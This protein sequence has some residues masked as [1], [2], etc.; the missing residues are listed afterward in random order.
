MIHD[1]PIDIEAYEANS[2]LFRREAW[3]AVARILVMTAVLTGSWVWFAVALNSSAF[4][5]SPW[6]VLGCSC[7]LSV[8]YV[9]SLYSAVGD[10][11]ITFSVYERPDNSSPRLRKESE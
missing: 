5:W 1:P 10:A 9:L 6:I 7:F 8:V 4:A 2:R 11:M 3:K